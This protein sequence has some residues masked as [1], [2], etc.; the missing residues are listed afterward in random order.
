M[1][2]Y[3]RTDECLR[4]GGPRHKELFTKFNCVLAHEEINSLVN[5]IK[6]GPFDLRLTGKEAAKGLQLSYFAQCL[7]ENAKTNVRES[8]SQKAHFAA[9]KIQNFAD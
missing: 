3:G 8:K 4:V 1:L 5:L 9:R 6:A 7:A 2:V